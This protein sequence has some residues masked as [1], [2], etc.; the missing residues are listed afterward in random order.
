[1]RACLHRCVCVRARVCYGGMDKIIE[2][3]ILGLGDS[4]MN[5]S[6]S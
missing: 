2:L 5:Y 4:I 6:L 1:M 3:F